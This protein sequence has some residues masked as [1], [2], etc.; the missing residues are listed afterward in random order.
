MPS[1]LVL[2]PMPSTASTATEAA[3]MVRPP[4]A[5][6]GLARVLQK[7]APGDTIFDRQ[8]GQRIVKLSE[9]LEEFHG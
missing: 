2:A 5:W 9:R 7:A 4:Y 8:T 1:Y 6:A 3:M